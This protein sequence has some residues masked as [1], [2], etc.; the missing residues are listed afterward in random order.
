MTS[1]PTPPPARPTV[2]TVAFW[3]QVAL[4]ATLV[5]VVA[6]SIADTVHYNGLIDEAVRTT[7]TPDMTSISWE[8]EDNIAG[9]LFVAVPMFVLAVWLGVSAIFVRRGSNVGRVLTWVGVGAPALL[10]LLSCL[11]GL[12]GVFAFAMIAIPFEDPSVYEDD[13]DFT[14]DDFAFSD[15]VYNLD[16]GGWS[17]AYDI[18]TAVGFVLILL[19]AVAVVVLLATSPAARWFRRGEPERR[20]LRPAFPYAT[21]PA[22]YYPAAGPYA[23]APMYPPPTTSY[24]YPY[25]YPYPAAW[26]A[27][28]PFPPPAAPFTPPTPPASPEPPPAV[29]GSVAPPEPNSDTRPDPD[30]GTPTDSDPGTGA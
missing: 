18:I 29:P 22:P 25:P 17:L 4:V 8:R 21:P 28:S 12:L 14:G 5:L 23:P 30:R 16:D 7:S 15:T 6:V 26:A 13:P 27:P 9:L 19:L 11:L 24:P 20:P 1:A 2:V 10:M 3:L